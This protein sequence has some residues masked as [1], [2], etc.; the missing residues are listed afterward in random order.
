MPR[1][2]IFRCQFKKCSAPIV[3]FEGRGRTRRYCSDECKAWEFQR[4]HGYVNAQISKHLAERK[5]NQALELP[6][7]NHHDDGR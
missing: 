3:Q 5:A 1:Q 6:E 2:A 4:R 7:V